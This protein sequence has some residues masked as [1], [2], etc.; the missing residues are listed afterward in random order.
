MPVLLTEKDH[1][2]EPCRIHVDYHA[3]SPEQNVANYTVAQAAK[4]IG[5]S[6]RTILS[7][8]LMLE[9]PEQEIRTRERENAEK[10]VPEVRLYHYATALLEEYER[11]KDDKLQVEAQLVANHLG[12]IVKGNQVVDG[13][14]QSAETQRPP[15]AAS[16]PTPGLKMPGMPGGDAAQVERSNMR[17]LGITQHEKGAQAAGKE[18]SA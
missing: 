17:Q 8:V 12:M 7:E 5:L 3:I 13:G 11:T 16:Q 1:L 4:T 15:Q 10:E 18:V 14:G 6:D 9:D 2:N